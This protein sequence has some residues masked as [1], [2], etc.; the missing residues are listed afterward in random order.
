MRGI[1]ST[2]GEEAEQ[3]HQQA[4]ELRERILGPDH[5]DTMKIET[6]SNAASG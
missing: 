4:L 2:R 3:I 5:P 1:A 6:T